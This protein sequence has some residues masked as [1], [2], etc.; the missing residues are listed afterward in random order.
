MFTD[1]P[2]AASVLI[3][4]FAAL[5]TI[6]IPFDVPP[7]IPPGVVAWGVG[8]RRVRSSADGFASNAIG[9]MTF[10]PGASRRLDPQADLD[11]LDR[12]DAHHRQGEPRVELAVPLGVAPQ[13]D[14]AAGHDCL[15]DPS[16]GVARLASGVDRGDDHGGRCRDSGCRPGWHRG[17]IRP[18]RTG[19][20]TIPPSSRTKPKTWMC[21][22]SRSSTFARAPTATRKG[23]LP[24][25]GA[26]QDLADAGLIIDRTGQINV[27]TRGERSAPGG[28]RAWRRC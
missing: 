1:G 5:T 11:R 20:A 4:F 28:V 7:S 10:E 14:R 3:G 25:A 22:V 15:D 12:L 2:R 19:S 26:F 6:G 18:S 8:T 23:R 17:P 9:S 21:Q 13:A 16:E 24:G 27:P